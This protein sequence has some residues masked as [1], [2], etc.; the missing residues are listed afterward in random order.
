MGERNRHAT[1]VSHVQLMSC[2]KCITCKRQIQKEEIEAKW[3]S[4]IGMQHM[5]HMYN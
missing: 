4:Q 3:E 2:G 5:Y 1:Y